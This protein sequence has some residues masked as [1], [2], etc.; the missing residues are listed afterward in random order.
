MTK[1][2]YTKRWFSI[3][4]LFPVSGGWLRHVHRMWA[5]GLMFNSH[6]LWLGIHYSP[7]NR[8]VCINL[9][10]CLTIWITAPGGNEP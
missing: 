3:T 1:R 9:I 2:L 10:P 6:A 7:G 8:R 5:V 4:A